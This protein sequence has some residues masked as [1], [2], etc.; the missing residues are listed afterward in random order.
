MIRKDWN[1]QIFRSQIEKNKAIVSKISECNK[2]GQPVLVFTS[3]VNNSENYSKLLR[4]EGIVHTILN[5]KNHEKEAEIIANAGKI[6][7]VIIQ[8]AYLEEVWIF[9]W[10]E[11]K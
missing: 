5:A 9:N 3:S 11:K 10:V 4:D 6:G 2:K 7:S 1:D 8:P